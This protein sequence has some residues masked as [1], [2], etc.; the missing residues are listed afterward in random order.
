MIGLSL[1]SIPS[2]GCCHRTRLPNQVTA[3]FSID[4]AAII[5]FVGVSFSNVNSPW[6]VDTWR[7]STLFQQRGLAWPSVHSTLLRLLPSLA[8]PSTCLLTNDSMQSTSGGD[9][10]E[11][12]APLGTQMI[13]T[14]SKTVRRSVLNP[15]AGNRGPGNG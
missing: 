7:P 14:T 1:P 15:V 3:K 11:G 2:Y 4:V 12:R 5:A 6:I 13:R 9:T 8:P 10:A